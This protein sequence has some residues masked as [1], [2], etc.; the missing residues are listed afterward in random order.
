MARG[1]G[2]H[3]LSVSSRCAARGR[4]VEREDASEKR[5]G[6]TEQPDGRILTDWR[7]RRWR[8]KQRGNKVR[9]GRHLILRPAAFLSGSGTPPG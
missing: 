1:E 4:R 9:E 5:K 7:A 3:M 6:R 2:R 8:F